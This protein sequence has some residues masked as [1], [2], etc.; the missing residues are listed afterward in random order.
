MFKKIS[1]SAALS[2]NRIIDKLAVSTREKAIKRAKTRILLHGRVVSDYSEE[3][4][5]TIVK[6]EEDKVIGEYRKMS[7]VALL[8][9][10]GIGVF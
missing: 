2:K 3:D 8:A 4:L 10:I 6:E 7:L 9:L 1:R 5:E